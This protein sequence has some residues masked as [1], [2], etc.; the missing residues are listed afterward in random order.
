MV[1]IQMYRLFA[2]ADSFFSV[3]CCS[4][5]ALKKPSGNAAFRGVFGRE[6]YPDKAS[7]ERG[8]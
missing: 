6:I 8:K 4:S 2:R 1:S 7:R 3:F 5:R